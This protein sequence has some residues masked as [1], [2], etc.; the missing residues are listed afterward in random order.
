MFEDHRGQRPPSLSG[1]SLLI[2]FHSFFLVFPSDADLLGEV[3]PKQI[4]VSTRSPASPSLP[5]PAQLSICQGPNF[6]PKLKVSDSNL[7]PNS[8][9]VFVFLILFFNFFLIVN[10]I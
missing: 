1:D 5:L 7:R 8:V 10:L 4:R 9:I 2:S 6:E 3:R